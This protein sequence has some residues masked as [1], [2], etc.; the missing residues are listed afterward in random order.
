[1]Q[2]ALIFI[3]LNP[4][5]TLFCTALFIMH[6]VLN[7]FGFIGVYADD[8]DIK[9]LDGKY[10]NS[11]LSDLKDKKELIADALGSD[12]RMTVRLQIVYGRLSIR[13]VRNAFAKSVGTRL[14]KFS[15]AEP[16]DTNELLQK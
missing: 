4:L 7:N 9:K 6:I 11:S 12:I 5:T 10:V 15:T 8:S 13:S 1:M 2:Q 14:Q 3:L 16:S